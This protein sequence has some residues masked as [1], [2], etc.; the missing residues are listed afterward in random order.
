MRDPVARDVGAAGVRRVGEPAV[1]V[2]GHDDPAGGGLAGRH[3]RADRG[4][5]AE[6]ADVIGGH[7]A[8]SWCAAE[9]LGDD[10]AV[11]PAEGEPERR[12]ACRV[13]YVRRRRAA[14]ATDRVGVDVAG[15]LLG[16]GEQVPAAVELHLG[17]TGPAAAQRPG[18]SRERC[19][20]AVW[21][22]VERGDL[23][24][25]RVDDVQLAAIVAERYRALG[26]QAPAGPG[27]PG[28]EGTGGLKRALAGA[29]KRDHRVA[30]RRVRGGVDRLR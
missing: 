11:A 20:R 22:D 7:G 2:V 6:R 29:V 5:A 15:G 18:R 10:Q 1:A 13:L 12:L 8:R 9:R 23:V 16:H 26:A 19:Q 17:R 4:D 25:A 28:G 30:R 21:G 14:V 3:R 27:S 24:A